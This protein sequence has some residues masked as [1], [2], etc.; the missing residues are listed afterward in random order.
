VFFASLKLRRASW[1]T[2]CGIPDARYRT[3]QAI[4]TIPCALGTVIPLLV[5]RRDE[6]PDD[7]VA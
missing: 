7:E 2:P 6:E 5:W 4:R 1:R 3:R